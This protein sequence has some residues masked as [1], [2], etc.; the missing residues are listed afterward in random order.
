MK[1]MSGDR[2]SQIKARKLATPEARVRY[3]QNLRTFAAIRQMVETVDVAREEAKISKTALA[4]AVGTTPSV[5]RRLLTNENGNPTLKTILELYEAVGL[6]I[7]VERIADGR[8]LGT[9]PIKESVG[10]AAD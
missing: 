5:V 10:L 3:D 6:R 1:P 4:N 2:W 7:R 8:E 9:I